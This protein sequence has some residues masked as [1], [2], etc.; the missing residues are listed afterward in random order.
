MFAV[1]KTWLFYLFYIQF[2]VISNDTRGYEARL[3]EASMSTAGKLGFV[4]AVCCP[5]NSG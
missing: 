5:D 1:V 2:I 3:R 4:Q